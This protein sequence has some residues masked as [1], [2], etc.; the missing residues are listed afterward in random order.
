MA[1]A[2]QAKPQWP[3]L[4]RA[5]SRYWWAVLFR[6]AKERL[7]ANLA[8][9]SSKCARLTTAGTGPTRN[10]LE[11]GCGTA[12]PCGRAIGCGAERRA[13]G[14]R[15]AYTSPVEVGLRKMPRI[16]GLDHRGLPRGVAHRARQGEGRV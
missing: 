15:C 10:Q 14:V 11:A 3:Q 12:G 16:V 4:T 7:V 8:C 1:R 5:R 2:V 9:T 6:R 13:V